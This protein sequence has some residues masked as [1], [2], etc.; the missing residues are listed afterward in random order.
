MR[1]LTIFGGATVFSKEVDVF[2]PYDVCAI[3][4]LHHP[5]LITNRDKIDVR[6]TDDGLPFRFGF[7]LLL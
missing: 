6:G 3:A 2:H 4:N 7:F 1:G 5:L